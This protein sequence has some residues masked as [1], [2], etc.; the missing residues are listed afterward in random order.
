MTAVGSHHVNVTPADYR[1]Q[2]VMLV[3]GFLR[4][5]PSAPF[6]HLTAAFREG[7]SA[8]EF[9]EGQNVTIEYRYA[10]NQADRLPIL[11]ADL[12]RR[13]QI[14]LIVANSL[15]A[16]AV[17]AATTTIPIVFVTGDDPVRSGLVANLNRPDANL[18]GVTFFANRQLHHATLHRGAASSFRGPRQLRIS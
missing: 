17:K 4:S 5:T 14:A 10:D 1:Q 11:A 7:L 3:I 13:P 16:M 2:P 8:G 6:V 18:T 15:A 9:V 12:V